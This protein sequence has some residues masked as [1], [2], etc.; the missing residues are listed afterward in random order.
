MKKI[1]DEAFAQVS[2]GSM[3]IRLKT[4]IKIYIKAFLSLLTGFFVE[5]CASCDFEK[6]LAGN[7]QLRVESSEIKQ[8]HKLDGVQRTSVRLHLLRKKLL[9]SF[10]IIFSVIIAGVLCVSFWDKCVLKNMLVPNRLFAILSILSFSWATLGRLGWEGQSFAGN[11]VFE[12][13]D[14]LIF[15]SLY[16]FGAF[17]GILAVASY[18]SQAG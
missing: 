8:K 1:I 2:L 17:F 10:I 16:W 11:T 18:A 9:F 15:K 12:D 5:D 14:K 3:R 4:P 6:E 7:K 13:L